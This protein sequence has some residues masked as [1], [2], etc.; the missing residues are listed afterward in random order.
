[1]VHDE[2]CPLLRLNFG[3]TSTCSVRVPRMRNFYP[4]IS[5][6]LMVLPIFF[7]GIAA[8]SGEDYS[9]STLTQL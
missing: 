2:P 5:V 7:G 8:G 4:L 9:T 1:M 6:V 3:V